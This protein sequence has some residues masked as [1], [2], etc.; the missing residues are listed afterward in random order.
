MNRTLSEGAA[1]LAPHGRDAA[2]ATSILREAGLAATMVP[3]VASLVQTLRTGAAFGI[4]TE[5]VLRGVDL[6]ELAGFIADQA[7]WSDFPFIVLTARGG[8]LERNPAAVRVLETLG[9]VTFLE[10][11]FH[12][13]TLVSLARAAR[14]AR[15]RQYEARSRLEEI[16]DGQ[17]RLRIALRAGGLGAWSMEIPSGLLG[18]SPEAGAHH[19]REDVEFT[20]LDL[21]AKILHPDRDG[22]R[23]AMTEAIASGADVDIQYRCRWPDGSIHWIKVNGRLERDNLGQPLRMVGV[24]QDVTVHREADSRRMALIALGDGL[25]Q[26]SDPAD[27]SF[28]ATKILGETFG[29]SR[30]GYGIIDPVSETIAIER[31]WQLPGIDSLAGILNFRDYGSYIDDLKRGETVAIADARLDPRTSETASVLEAIHARAVLNMPVVDHGDFV[32]LLYLNHEEPRAWSDTDLAFVRNVADRTQAAIERCQAEISLAELAA[33]LERQ[34]EERT[35]ENEVAQEQLRQAQK[36]EAV[37]QLTGGIA[38]DF[39]NLLTGVAGGLELMQMRISQGRAGEVEKYLEMAQAATKRAAALTHRLLAF[40]RR[41][42]LDPKPTDIDR[43]VAGMAEFLNRSVGPTIE[44]DMRRTDDL[45]TALIDPNQLENALLNLCINARDAM[46]DGG[47]IT[48]ETHNGTG[49]S[50]R[51]GGTAE[52]PPGDYVVLSVADTGTGMTPETIERA[53]DPFYTTKPLGEGTGLGLSMIYGFVKQ[54]GGHVRIESELGSGTTMSLYFPRV[55]SEEEG[56]NS[57][58]RQGRELPPAEGETV[59]VVDDEPAIRTLITDV[60]KELG[61]K[62]LEATDGAEG[63]DL[64]RKQQHVELLI[65]DVGLPKGMNG[66]QLADAAR[67]D[68]PELKILFITGYAE[69]AVMGSSRMEAGMHVLTKPFAMDTLAGRIRE[70]ISG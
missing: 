3:D 6:R 53:F 33:S 36:M 50:G 51:A 44:I 56:E 20:Y 12:P 25:R 5:E 13:T 46:P 27:M 19:G 70:L 63:L 65:T 4:V 49:P 47:S 43:L 1:I 67:V 7:E 24:T 31:D 37:G 8:G 2:V 52:F 40:S 18:V 54:S 69:S 14:R 45:W 59:L 11:P 55:N 26:L 28:L 29:V 32:A 38:H 68:R 58:E 48:I 9:N 22:T 21:L 10:R 39:N 23:A 42:T 17:E 30:A 35:R 60:L 41:Q 61:Y 57:S 34:V 62:T 16:R 66:R 64:L 15:L